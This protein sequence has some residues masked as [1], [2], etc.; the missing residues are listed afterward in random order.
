MREPISFLI[1]IVQ[2]FTTNWRLRLACHLLNITNT[3]YW[4]FTQLPSETSWMWK[5]H[6]E[7]ENYFTK[8]YDS[9]GKLNRKLPVCTEAYTAERCYE[10]TYIHTIKKLLLSKENWIVSLK[11][12]III[13]HPD[14]EWGHREEFSLCCF[15]ILNFPLLTLPVDNVMQ[16]HN[17]QSTL[18]CILYVCCHDE[19]FRGESFF[20][21][22]RYFADCITLEYFIILQRN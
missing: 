20:K 2:N 17:I 6:F 9:V 8:Q 22:G 7:M 10:H 13:T 15:N 16:L 11:I 4:H 1:C 21:F 19:H 18:L 12:I 14:C 3:S 5:L